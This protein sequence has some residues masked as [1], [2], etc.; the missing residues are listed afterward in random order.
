MLMSYIHIHRRLAGKFFL[1]D[2]S[3]F[4]EKLKSHDLF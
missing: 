2:F 1:A 4:N 3:L